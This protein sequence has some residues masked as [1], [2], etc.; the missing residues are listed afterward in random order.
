MK[1]TQIKLFNELRRIYNSFHVEGLDHTPEVRKVDS[2]LLALL[3][4]L[5]P[6]IDLQLDGDGGT[7]KLNEKVDYDHFINILNTGRWIHLQGTKVF[8]CVETN[9]LLL[10]REDDEVIEYIKELI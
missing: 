9:E 1:L 4:S 6:V 10:V 7:I 3:D 5:V 8:E 2:T